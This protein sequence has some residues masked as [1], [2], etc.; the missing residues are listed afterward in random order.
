MTA[1][2][3]RLVGR[4]RDQIPLQVGRCAGDVGES[5]HDHGQHL[6]AVRVGVL[7][8]VGALEAVRRCA[9]AAAATAAASRG[10]LP[11]GHHA[12]RHLGQAR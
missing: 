12:G 10:P 1:H 4:R 5:G 3:H 8:H 7:R 11:V 9:R 6:W 2:R